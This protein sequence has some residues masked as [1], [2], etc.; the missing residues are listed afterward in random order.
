MNPLLAAA[1]HVLDLDET[2]RRLAPDHPTGWRTA[3]WKIKTA[4][5]D[6]VARAHHEAHAVTLLH[7]AGL[8]PARGVHGHLG[9][10]VWTAVEWR[11][12]TTVWD[13]CAPAREGR[14]PTP[15]F[16]QELLDVA[17][18]AFDALARL[19][20][21]GWH[22]GD[23]QPAN[24]VVTESGDVEFIDL[25]FTQHPTLLPLPY[26]YRGGMD[27]VTAPEIAERLLHTTTDVHLELTDAA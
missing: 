9:E 4:T 15:G 16:E 13:L 19:H 24:I 17:H 10:G 25:D 6:R 20:T 8:Y 7:A 14:V 23:V 5:G 12:G 21:A 11:P 18:A 22:H 3:H 1:A 27:H 26:P 2:P